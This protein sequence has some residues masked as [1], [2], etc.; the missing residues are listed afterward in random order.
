MKEVWKEIN[1]YKDYRVS[2]MGQVASFKSGKKVILKQK[3]DRYGY[4]AVVLSGGT[5]KTRKDFTVHRLVAI[6]FV[7]GYADGLQVNHLNEIKTDNRADNLMWATAKENANYGSRNI[8]MAQALSLPVV[9]LDN[10]GQVIKRF[11]GINQAER[12][13]GIKLSSFRRRVLKNKKIGGYRWA[14]AN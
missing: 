11:S 9:M 5:K 12:E 7:D 14:Y 3:I 1:G 4:C 10:N 6:H 2:N 13:T 8:R